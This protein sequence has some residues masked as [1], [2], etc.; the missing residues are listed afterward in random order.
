MD[1]MEKMERKARVKVGSEVHGKP[2]FFL[3]GTVRAIQKFVE[4][5]ELIWTDP[6]V[7]VI[8]NLRLD[9]YDLIED[10]DSTLI[11]VYYQCGWRGKS[12]I[13]G[14]PQALTY[15][16]YASQRGSLGIS[17]GVI[18]S[19]SH[20]ES[21]EV[22]ISGRRDGRLYGKEEEFSLTLSWKDRVVVEEE[23]PIVWSLP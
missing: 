12:K 18:F 19:I 6:D 11:I 14:P 9:G 21:E 17:E 5:R 10:K 4:E 20:S 13:E 3:S 2:S 7:S 22:K 23:C 15:K 8:Y 16:V 1:K